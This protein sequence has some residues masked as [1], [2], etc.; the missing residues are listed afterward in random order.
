MKI[1]EIER[2]HGDIEEHRHQHQ[3]YWHPKNRKHFIETTEAIKDSWGHAGENSQGSIIAEQIDE[4]GRRAHRH[5]TNYPYFHPV[6]RLHP[7]NVMPPWELSRR[8]L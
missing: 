6:T 1:I 2:I 5:G 8:D 7:C 3:D 4:N